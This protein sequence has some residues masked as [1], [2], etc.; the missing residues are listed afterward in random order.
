MA[1]GV[2]ALFDAEVG[3]ATT[4]VGGPDPDEGHE[5][6]TVWIAVRTP[7]DTRSERFHLRG[8]SPDEICSLSCT[9]AVELARRTLL[10]CSTA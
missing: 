1:A 5:P 10:Q 3:L 6:G 8:A 2:A 4:G 7:A 9:Q